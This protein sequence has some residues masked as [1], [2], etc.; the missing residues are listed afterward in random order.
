MLRLI[1]KLFMPTLFMIWGT[2]YFI[3]VCGKKAS[4][5]YFIKP[6]YI[7][8][9]VLY[10]IN[11]VKEIRDW[12][13]EVKENSEEAKAANE[14]AG[15]ELKDILIFVG[16]IA[17]YIVVVPYLGFVITS[18]LFLYIAF[19]YFKTGRGL[20]ILV[21]VLM[22]AAI[23]IIFKVVLGVPLPEGFLGF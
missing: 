5:G 20:A 15:R 19:R 8:F 4:T 3:E 16:A 10:V 11:T 17:V 1:Q 18:L 7:A 23:Y 12:R 22:V 13:M 14:K 21:D 2:F 9:A 6:V